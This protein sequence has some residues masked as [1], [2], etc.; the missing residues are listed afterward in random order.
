MNTKPK[1]LL[2]GSGRLVKHLK[3]WNSLLAKP[4][5]IVE[6]KR[7]QVL[8]DLSD[9]THAWLA[10][11]DSA[12]AEVA[13]ILPSHLTKV[14]FSGA[15]Q[16]AGTSCAH[17]LMSFTENLLPESVYNEIYFVVSGQQDLQSLLPG[18]NNSFAQINPEHKA[19]YHALCVLTGNI[20]QLLWG[21]TY[22]EFEKLGI[23]KIA[24]DLFLKQ[25]SDNFRNHGIAAL[26]GPIARKDQVSI[27]KN[28][29]ALSRTPFLK[30]IYSL[31]AGE[32]AP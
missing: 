18:F 11:S 32:F 31:F 6:W 10:V 8:P 3:F 25:S 17:P 16:I 1:V 22:A 9:F 23:P 2:A 29:G 13:S 20:P 5:Q 14:H 24:V 28:L 19:F 7:Y 12:I 21:Q 30:K 4:N 15:L 26:T 27:E